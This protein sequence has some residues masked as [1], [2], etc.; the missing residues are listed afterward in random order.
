MASKPYPSSG[1]STGIANIWEYPPGVSVER[2]VITDLHIHTYTH[3]NTNTHTH[4][5]YI[6]YME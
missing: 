3:I 4:E 2:K 5:L 6:Q 1:T